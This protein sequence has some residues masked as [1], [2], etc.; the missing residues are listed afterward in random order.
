M[1]RVMSRE[2]WSTRTIRTVS[3]SGMKNATCLPTTKLRN[4][5]RKSSLGRPVRGNAA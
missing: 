2:P 4:P 1:V 3:P 5:G